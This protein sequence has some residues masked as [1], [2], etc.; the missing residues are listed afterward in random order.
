MSNQP[1]ASVFY[2]LGG[3]SF[4]IL[5]VILFILSPRHDA[6]TLLPVGGIA[7]AGALE[8]V[9]YVGTRGKSGR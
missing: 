6:G 1:D 2:L 9:A 4:F 5:A 3:I 7:I 8:I